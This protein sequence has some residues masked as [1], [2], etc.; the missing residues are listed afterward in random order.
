MS[1]LL[2]L[3][4]FQKLAVGGGWVVKRHFSVPLWSK[5]WTWDLK[6]GPSWT[7]LTITYTVWVWAVGGGGML[8]DFWRPID[9][10]WHKYWPLC[11]LY[12]CELSPCR[13]LSWWPSYVQRWKLS[14]PRP[15]QNT[16][17]PTKVGFTMNMTLQYHPLQP[18]PPKTR[19]QP[20]AAQPIQIL[21]WGED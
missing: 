1:I 9:A 15:S 4:P 5:P 19:T 11:I 12:G 10:S 18:H 14:K 16:K 21:T 20:N 17:Q 3:E 8:W 6:L 2:G 7:I 13:T